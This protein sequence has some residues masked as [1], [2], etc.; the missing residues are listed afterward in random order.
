MWIEYKLTHNNQVLYYLLSK[1]KFE[2][3]LSCDNK[4]SI[5]V[6]EILYLKTNKSIQNF[7]FHT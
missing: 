3:Q 5:D 6:V 2:Q 4:K 1:K 7:K